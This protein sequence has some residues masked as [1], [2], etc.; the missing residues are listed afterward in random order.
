MRRTTPTRWLAQRRAFFRESEMQEALLL[1][2]PIL[3]LLICRPRTR[4]LRKRAVDWKV[5]W[6]KFKSELEVRDEQRDDH[7]DH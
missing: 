3:F 4:V 2:A 6:G 7:D 5:S 1:L